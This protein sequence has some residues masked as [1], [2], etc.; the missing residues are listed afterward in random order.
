VS[1]T[2][3]Q[4]KDMLH[5]QIAELNDTSIDCMLATYELQILEMEDE[6][7]RVK[8]KGD[9][10][11]YQREC[12]EALQAI[13]PE[14]VQSDYWVNG[15]KRMATELAALRADRDRLSRELENLRA[16]MVEVPA[17]R[18]DLVNDFAKGGMLIGG[19][20]IHGVSNN[21]FDCPKCHPPLDLGQAIAD[22]EKQLKQ[23]M[24]AAREPKPPTR[25]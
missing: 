6:L 5:R 22:T 10:A 12:F 21:G 14:F 9:D 24:S 1:I 17:P 2:R 4:K 18:L 25:P 7:A 11:T 20:C 19:P 3:E 8:A 13:P 16:Q 15:V 23:I